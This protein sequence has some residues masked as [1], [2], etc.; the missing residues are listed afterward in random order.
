MDRRAIRVIAAL[1]AVLTT[2]APAGADAARSKGKIAYLKRPLEVRAISADGKID[3]PFAPQRS[4]AQ[5]GPLWSPNGRL[6]LFH[7]DDPHALVTVTPGKGGHKVLYQGQDEVS[8][9]PADYAWSPNGRL[10]AL[11]HGVL[12]PGPFFSLR[13]PL[14]VMN[15]DGSARRELPA[16]DNPG[17]I[18]WL[19]DNRRIAFGRFDGATSAMWTIDIFTGA[20]VKLFDIPPGDGNFHLS[21]NGQMW[22]FDR[23]FQLWVMRFDGTGAR[24]VVKRTVAYN[25]AWSPDGREL[26]F[27][28]QK[29]VRGSSRDIYKVRLNGSGLKRLT[30]HGRASSVHWG[31]GTLRKRGRL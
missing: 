1:A 27:L 6:V 26:A 13:N 22:V 9:A 18:N 14:S 11:T 30:K 15:A 16:G 23:G 4:G 24:A 10:I 29:G 7:R 25:G 5:S 20:Q 31:R 8:E 3:K 19:P 12:A 17:G 28:I 2:W 21:P